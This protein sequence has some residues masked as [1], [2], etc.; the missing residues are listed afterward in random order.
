MIETKVTIFNKPEGNMAGVITAGVNGVC[1]GNAYL[2]TDKEPEI[3]VHFVKS[4]MTA[5][6][7]E[8]MARAVIQ[9]TEVAT[10][11]FERSLESD[12]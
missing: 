6:E 4:G 11:E 9:L 3:S 8:W 2:Y 10:A 5:N 7:A 1:V 12:L